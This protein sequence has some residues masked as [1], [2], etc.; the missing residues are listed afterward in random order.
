MQVQAIV[1]T[2]VHHGFAA[3]YLRNNPVV[4]QYRPAL[5]RQLRR[6]SQAPTPNSAERLCRG[7]RN[8]TDYIYE[9]HN[10]TRLRLNFRP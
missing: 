9:F 7:V 6:H 4:P 2:V 3:F 5:P 8:Y 1:I 10:C